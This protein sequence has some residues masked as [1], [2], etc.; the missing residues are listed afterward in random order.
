MYQPWQGL[1]R[2][3]WNQARVAARELK[4]RPVLI[5]KWNRSVLYAMIYAKDAP[6]MHEFGVLFSNDR[7]GRRV[8]VIRFEDL[9]SQVVRRVKRN[10]R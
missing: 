1:F 5:F 10:G 2:A 8:I 3:W 6:D 7:H 4:A 9:L